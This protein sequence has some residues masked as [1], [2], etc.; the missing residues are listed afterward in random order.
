[1]SGSFA[2]ATDRAAALVDTKPYGRK[3][4]A[5]HLSE[6]KSFGIWRR[7]GAMWPDEPLS[8]GRVAVAFDAYRVT[9]NAALRVRTTLNQGVGARAIRVN[10]RPRDGAEH[11]WTRIRMDVDFATR[12]CAVSVDGK[13]LGAAPLPAGDA[14]FDGL[15]FDAEAGEA[16]VDDIRVDWRP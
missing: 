9:S 7:T 16:L 15:I 1:M 13:E 2:A 5:V 3:G 8:T 4:R 14:S 6:G 11:A 12:A 10:V